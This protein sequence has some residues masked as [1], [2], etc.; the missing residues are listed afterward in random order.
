MRT[1][2]YNGEQWYRRDW[3]IFHRVRHWFIWIGGWEKANGEG[4]KIFRWDNIRSAIQYKKFKRLFSPSW[5][6]YFPA[7]IS[8]FGHRFTWMGWDWGWQLTTKFGYLVYS[9]K[10][11]PKPIL[12]LSPDGTPSSATDFYLNPPCEIINEVKRNRE[13]R[14]IRD[15]EHHLWKSQQNVT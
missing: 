13:E 6:M 11:H 3:S 10:G 7:P 14:L 15:A 12:Y 4:W 9:K 1:W 2:H 8:F 5:V